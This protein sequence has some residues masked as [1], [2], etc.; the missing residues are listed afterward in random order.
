[1]IKALSLL[2]ILGHLILR[3]PVATPGW[4]PHTPTA[5]VVAVPV[6]HFG[7][8][9][10]RQLRRE[11]ASKQT[12]QNTCK[13]NT[14]LP[15]IRALVVCIGAHPR[16]G[17]R[18]PITTPGGSRTTFIKHHATTGSAVLLDLLQLQQVAD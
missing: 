6:C 4:V 8:E 2:S 18:A 11:L 5:A 14:T 3:I 10:R 1:M 16:G 9:L 7:A 17:D 15:S 12:P 13:G